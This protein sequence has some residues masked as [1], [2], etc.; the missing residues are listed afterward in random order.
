VL[1]LPSCDAIFGMPFLNC[2]KLMIHSAK[3]IVTLNDIKLPL[4]KDHDDEHPSIS[5][6]TR[7]RLKAEIRKNEIAELYLATA[8]ITSEPSKT[9]TPDWIND[10]YSDVFLDGLPHGK[11]PERK[12]VH[13]I[14]L[15]P[16]SPA[17]F[18]GIFRLSQIELRKQLSQLLTDGKISPSTVP[19][20]RRFSL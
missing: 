15:Y 6:I 18:R 20:A 2:R 13:E 11:P 12:V 9:T 10:E 17:Q 19:M 1:P 8:K 3:D 16:D 5:M 7:S 14:P 4:F